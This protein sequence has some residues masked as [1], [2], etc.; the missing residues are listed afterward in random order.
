M[1]KKA[2][3]KTDSVALIASALQ[4]AKTQTIR[5]INVQLK[6]MSP[7]ELISLE[8]LIGKR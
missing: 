3:K 1:A 7:T 6:R 5:R 8:R 4:S 2:K